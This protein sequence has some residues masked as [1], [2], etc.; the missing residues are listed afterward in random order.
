MYELYL[1]RHGD[2][3]IIDTH[4]NIILTFES[5]AEALNYITDVL[6]T[7]NYHITYEE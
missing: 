5:E 6:E 7:T 2:A 1:Y 4:D 3:L